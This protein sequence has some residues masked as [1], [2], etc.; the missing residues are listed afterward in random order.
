MTARP[1]RARTIGL[2]LAITGAMMMAASAAQADPTFHV[3]NASG[4]IYWRTAPDWNTAAA[5]SG[6]GVYDDTTIAVHCYATGTAVPGS[7]DT[8]WEQ[9]TVVGGSGHGSGWLNEHF[10]DDG[11]AINQ[12]SPGVPPCG[13][14]GTTMPPPPPPPPPPPSPPPPLSPSPPPPST[15]SSSPGPGDSVT[16]WEPV[17]VCVLQMLAQPTNADVVHAVDVLIAHESSG[18]PTI[19]N[20]WDSNA[21]AGHPSKGLTQTIPSTFATHRSP[22][23]LDDIFDPAANI[24]AGLHYGITRYG[25]ITDIPGIRNVLNGGGYVGYAA[26]QTRRLGRGSRCGTVS[27]RGFKLTLNAQHV[28]CRVARI[29]AKLIDA[30]SVVRSA[31]ALAENVPVTAIGRGYVCDIDGLGRNGAK[32]A[33]FCQ[34]GQRTLW[35]SARKR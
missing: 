10:I 24:Y 4:G 9:A 27:L 7:A 32:R 30:E 23:L 33:V 28:T 31:K 35:W 8:M 11:A 26:V 29:A 21:M 15:C 16:R 14:P 20:L 12:P 22:L 17:I 5:Q 3:M 34:S 25:S 1:R 13:S 2:F 18:D 19:V 6:N